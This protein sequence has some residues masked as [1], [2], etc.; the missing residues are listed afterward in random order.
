MYKISL[1]CVHH[2]VLRKHH[3]TRD[4]KIN[5]IVKIAKDLG[6][7]HATSALSPY[8][9]LF[10]RTEKFEK[11]VLSKELSH[12]K[13]LARVCY[14]R[15]AI[16]ILPRDFI[17]L[18]FAATNRMAG[19]LSDRHYRYF[20][21]S[22]RDYDKISSKILDI[23]K[24][25]G[26]S[27]REIKAKLRTSRSITPLVN[28]MCDRGLLIRGFSK[29]GWKSNVHTYFRI[30]DYYPE[31][32]LMEFGEEEA[33]ESVIK[34]YIASFGPVTEQD[35]AWWTGFPVKQV[36]KVLGKLEKEISSVEISG[37][38]GRFF[39]LSSELEVLRSSE[40]PKTPVVNLLPHLDPYLTG[41]KHRER[42]LDSQ[43]HEMI[44]DRSGNATA[45]ILVDGQII[46]VWDFDEPW[47]KF[48]LF[49][50]VKK[51]IMD[52]IYSEAAE[53][54]TFIADRVVQIKRCDSMVPLTHR[55]AG[56]FMSPLKDC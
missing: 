14:V 15:N 8:L 20:G 47:I 12:R 52:M 48:C 32:N 35:I 2:F 28:L 1:D 21:F 41:Y 17:P 39:L 36:R 13:S 25:R 56:A 6:G 43:Y 44:L 33:R 22:P 29:E 40:P 31:L 55:T 38:D 24:G 9:S 4:S 42:Y 37:L 34:Q 53:I 16:Y 46:G 5:D 19:V 7:L 23:L 54:G 18:A 27:A 49:K 10:A 3:L 30:M 50:E 45:T 51:K 11:A 26:L